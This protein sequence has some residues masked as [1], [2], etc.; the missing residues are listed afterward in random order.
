M[1]NYG[2]GIDIVE[3]RQMKDAVRKFGSSFLNRVFHP[4]EITRAKNKP[5]DYRGYAVKFAAKE[6]FLKA[7]GTGWR[8]GISWKEIEVETRRGRDIEIKLHGKTL[9]TAGKL[10]VGRIFGSF[11]YS[12]DYS[13]SQVIVER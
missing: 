3:N 2:T 10:G 1:I 5:E 9:Q 12:G 7:M 8:K 4:N 11:S 6:A 13:L